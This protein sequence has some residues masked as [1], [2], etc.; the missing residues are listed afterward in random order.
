MTQLQPFS[1][2]NS[3]AQLAQLLAITANVCACAPALTR[4]SHDP[5]CLHWHLRNSR[6][7]GNLVHREEVLMCRVDHPL[8]EGEGRG[9]SGHYALNPL[10]LDVGI[11][12]GFPLLI[13]PGIKLLNKLVQN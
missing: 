6:P 9:G 8:G 3:L 7:T 11:H 1:T 2:P 10:P 12:A 13:K 5:I 4:A